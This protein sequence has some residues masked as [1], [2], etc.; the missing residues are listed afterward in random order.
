MRVVR[1]GGEPAHAR[2][3]A[4]ATGRVV[5]EIY[6]NPIAPPPDHPRTHSLTLHLA[7]SVE[8]IRAERRRLLEAGATVEDDLEE[9]A[10]GDM[11][12]ML[13]DPW[14]LPLQL[15]RRAEPMV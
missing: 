5:L 9:T 10:A 12:L 13:R 11:V 6:R 1:S 3:L 4:D 15:V 7:F 14:G 8:D 2:F